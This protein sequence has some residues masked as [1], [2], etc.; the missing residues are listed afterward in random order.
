MKRVL[1]LLLSA[2]VAHAQAV[3]V[4]LSKVTIAVEGMM[5]SKS[6]AT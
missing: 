5:K 1:I 3:D 2:L 4:S 6:G